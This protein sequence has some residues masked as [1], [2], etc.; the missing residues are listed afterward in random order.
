MSNPATDVCWLL[1]GLVVGWAV[2]WLYYFYKRVAH[3]PPSRIP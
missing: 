3:E 1:T 2:T